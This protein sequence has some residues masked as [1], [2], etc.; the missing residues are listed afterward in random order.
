MS[1]FKGFIDIGGDFSPDAR[2]FFVIE[3]DPHKAPPSEIAQMLTE[4]YRDHENKTMDFGFA[5]LGEEFP[6]KDAT[7][8]AWARQFVD[9]FP[10]LLGHMVD[11]LIM[12]K[13][14]WPVLN[15]PVFGRIR[16]LALAGF[17][18]FRESDGVARPHVDVE[19]KA[20]LDGLRG[21]GDK[22]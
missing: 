9:G 21:T 20:I 16:F 18:G 8:Q 14:G 17:G 19:G 4:H 7:S 11:E 13:E 6:W 2:P 22:N 5:L 1:G 10:S 3:V 12:V 15:I